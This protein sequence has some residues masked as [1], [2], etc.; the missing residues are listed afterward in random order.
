MLRRL[1]YRWRNRRFPYHKK[2][3]HVRLSHTDLILHSK[4]E[5]LHQLLD[6]NLQNNLLKLLIYGN[7]LSNYK[8]LLLLVS[9]KYE[10]LGRMTYVMPGRGTMKPEYDEY[11]HYLV[12][13]FYETVGEV[14]GHI[15][16][17]LNEKIEYDT[18]RKVFC[19]LMFVME[20]II[21]CMAY[22]QDRIYVDH[23]R[24]II[25]Y[26]IEHDCLEKRK[27]NN[28]WSAFPIKDKN[29]GYFYD[30]VFGHLPEELQDKLRHI[31]YD[32]GDYRW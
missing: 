23:Y 20:S 5:V 27:M 22:R 16:S 29:T 3:E 15:E 30:R 17:L 12:E 28:M 18:A 13:W 1:R 26:A 7:K 25:E 6:C 9:I 32:Y 2:Y 21:R 8:D 24:T 4:D 31:D 11:T 10:L 14:K 19:K